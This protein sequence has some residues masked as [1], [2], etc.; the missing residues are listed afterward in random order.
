MWPVWFSRNA[1]VPETHCENVR[2]AL[3]VAD[4]LSSLTGVCGY[5]LIGGFF[6][7]CL[8]DR[9]LLQPTSHVAHR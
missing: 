2:R 3:Y 4:N 6:A 9:G 1:S 5:I 8:T 7:D